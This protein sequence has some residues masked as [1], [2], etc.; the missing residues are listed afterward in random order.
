MVLVHLEMERQAVS[1]I[2]PSLPPHAVVALSDEKVR[3]ILVM[4]VGDY[5][6]MVVV[7]VAVVVVVVV[8]AAAAV[9]M[10]VVV[11]LMVSHLVVVAAA[12]AAVEEEYHHHHLVVEQRMEMTVPSSVIVH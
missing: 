2:S 3:Q 1:R 9:V 11:V 10:T 12:V 7:V 6:A 8:V 4:L 5:D